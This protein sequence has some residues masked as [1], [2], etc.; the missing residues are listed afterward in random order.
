MVRMALYDSSTRANSGRVD[1]LPTHLTPEA[2]GIRGPCDG[3]IIASPAVRIAP[4]LVAAPGLR[5]PVAPWSRGPAVASRD[6]S[7]TGL[8]VTTTASTPGGQDVGRGQ[9]NA[10]AFVRSTVR[11]P[12]PGASLVSPP[13]GAS[14][15]VPER[16]ER[17][18]EIINCPAAAARES[19]RAGEELV[20]EAYVAHQDRLQ[21]R[22]W[23]GTRDVHAAEDV[24]QDAFE[25]LVVEVRAN[26]TPT[27]VG[28]WLSRVST[29]LV[30]SRGRRIAVARRKCREVPL[31]G[32]APSPETLI[33]LAERDIAL[34]QALSELRPA[35][36]QALVLAAQGYPGPEIARHLGRSVGATRTL[37]CRARRQIRI[38]LGRDWLDE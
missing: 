30:T 24:V 33:L 27:N 25:R 8:M 17:R 37:I 4:L 10:P 35:E 26:R 1:G 21:H 7:G 14:V 15:P 32:T 29:N 28:A 11:R 20:V 19:R 34:R 3:T 23:R 9:E 31:P 13:P 2:G 18:A 12:G 16:K 5:A 6:A 36:R 38:R 22:L